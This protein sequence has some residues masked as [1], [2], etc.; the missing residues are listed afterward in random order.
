MKL[1]IIASLTKDRVIGKNRAVPWDIPEDMQRFK[2]LTTGHPVLMGRGT[3]ETLSAPLTNR[4]NV[5]LS[6][7]PIDG[8]ETYPTIEKALDALRNEGDVYLIGGGRIFA[9]L[10]TS[11]SELRLTIVERSVEGDTYFPPYEH[12]VGSMFQL[13]SR[14]QH[15]GFLFE[16]YVRIGEVTST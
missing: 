11:A 4:R 12:L 7:H 5:V 6:S 1:I 14:E 10:L 15:E 9:P 8:V 13:V 3:Y 2:R 16:D